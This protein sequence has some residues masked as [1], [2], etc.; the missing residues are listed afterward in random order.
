MDDKPSQRHSSWRLQERKGLLPAAAK[1][2]AQDYSSAISQKEPGISDEPEVTSDRRIE[3][4][5]T[6]RRVCRW[7]AG[8]PQGDDSEH[9]H[10]EQERAMGQWVSQDSVAVCQ[11]AEEHEP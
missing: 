3:R 2:E 5:P 9:H 8:V 6:A 1:V 4:G 11:H 10:A 7:P